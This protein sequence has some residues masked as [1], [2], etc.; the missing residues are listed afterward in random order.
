MKNRR[1]LLGE[2]LTED[3]SAGVRG[4]VVLGGMIAVEGK[5]SVSVQAARMR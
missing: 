2:C 3:V 4:V 1:R 5:I